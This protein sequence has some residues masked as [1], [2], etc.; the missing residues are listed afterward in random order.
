MFQTFGTLARK[1]IENLDTH[2]G[3]EAY[4][5]ETRT[6]SLTSIA[7]TTCVP[8]KRTDAITDSIFSSVSPS[9]PNTP[10]K[11]TLPLKSLQHLTARE[12]Q[13]VVH[14]VAEHASST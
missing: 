14:K 1:P 10:L 4:F 6:F 9:H 8:N 3:S 2:R 13:Y 5:E 12:M 7:V 11:S